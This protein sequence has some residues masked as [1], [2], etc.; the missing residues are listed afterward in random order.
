MR[1]SKKEMRSS[2]LL[3]TALALCI[4]VI[5]AGCS[6]T[7]V[8][9]KDGR[10]Y[11]F[12]SKSEGLYKM[13]CESGDLLKILNDTQLPPDIKDNLYKYN[14]VLSERSKDKVKEIYVSLKPEQRRD[15]RLTFQKHGYDI[16]YLA[17]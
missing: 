15:L 5:I 3:I 17:C 12:G 10:G 16:N 13:M 14:C 1:R 11:F 7:F 2:A 6:S 9:T 8:V 4:P